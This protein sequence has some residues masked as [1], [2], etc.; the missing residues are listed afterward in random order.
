MRNASLEVWWFP[1]RLEAVGNVIIFISSLFGSQDAMRSYTPDL[2]GCRTLLVA[3]H[4][5]DYGDGGERGELVK[6]VRN[7]NEYRG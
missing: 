7:C 4:S 3:A 1:E 2:R 5:I 6:I